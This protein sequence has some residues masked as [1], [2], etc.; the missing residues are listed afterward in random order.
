MAKRKHKN[1]RSAA[2]KRKD[3]SNPTDSLP[4]TT[5][6]IVVAGFLIV[7]I[8]QVICIIQGAL[9]STDISILSKNVWAL[10]QDILTQ[11]SI[12]DLYRSTNPGGD[13]SLPTRPEAQWYIETSAPIHSL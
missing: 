5:K 7:G 2:T 1:N 6:E 12:Y 8:L 3:N 4:L 13:N 11:E 10:R 9:L